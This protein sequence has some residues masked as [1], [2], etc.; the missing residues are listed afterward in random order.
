MSAARSCYQGATG[1]STNKAR[2]AFAAEGWNKGATR[3]GIKM[4]SVPALT[5]F[6]PNFQ[7][8]AG[9][10]VSSAASTGEVPSAE[11]LGAIGCHSCEGRNGS[12][13]AAASGR[14]SCEGHERSA[15]HG[16]SVEG[17]RARTLHRADALSALLSHD[18]AHNVHAGHTVDVGHMSTR[19]SSELI[20]RIDRLVS[21][22][23]ERATFAT[24]RSAVLRRVIERGLGVVEQEFGIADSP[25]VGSSSE[26]STP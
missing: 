12:L 22:V 26:R 13:F 21:T 14:T 11:V 24:T 17:V 16:R 15:R 6:C 7:T 20:A 19:L 1:S 25:P 4:A 10:L 23:G 3:I 8:K 9:D 2:S 18:L 5:P